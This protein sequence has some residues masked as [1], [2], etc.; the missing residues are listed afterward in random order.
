MAGIG[1]ATSGSVRQF[2]CS[3]A[4]SI[5][6]T[7][8]AACSPFGNGGSPLGS[9]VLPAPYDVSG[10][11]LDDTGELPDHITV[12]LAGVRVEVLDGAKVGTVAISDANGQYR[13]PG[14]PAGPVQMRA[15]KEGYDSVVTSYTLIGVLGP[16][17]T[18]P[19]PPHTLWGN[20]FDR[21]TA[22]AQR[23]GNV[24]VRVFTGPNAS[25]VT[26]TNSD[27]QYRLDDLVASETMDVA[28]VKGGFQSRS[29]RVV[30]FR[31]NTEQDAVLL[32]N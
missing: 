7:A 26:T 29:Y 13:L 19:Q 12:P 1:A 15:S 3:I 22:G 4:A 2:T 8:A 32:P 25:R 18:L 17:F 30:S 6:L 23:V 10:Y 31:K 5:L 21:E 20:V 24:T 28:F 27:G 9:G 16:Y 11:T 14:M